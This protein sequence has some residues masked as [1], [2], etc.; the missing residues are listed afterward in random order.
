L[1]LK[2]FCLTV[3]AFGVLQQASASSLCTTGTLASYEALGAGGCQI[4][5]DT[6]G[7]FAII[8]GITGATAIDPALVEIKP[9][10]G[11]D[12]LVLKFD[13]TQTANA[14]SLLEAIFTYAISGPDPFITDMTTLSN[15]SETGDGDVSETQNY[16]VGGRFGPDGV[17][18]CTGST[19]GT[20]LTLDGIQNTD[21][22]S[23]TGATTLGITDDFVL[24][25]GTAGSASGGTF[26]D[27]FTATST[28]PEP[29]CI[30]LLPAIALVSAG[31]R[32]LRSLHRNS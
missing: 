9:S 18:G 19:S 25:G 26:V 32:K 21:Q 17:D 4:G 14:G 12:D 29:N 16:C 24:D 6:I 7:S 30:F 2:L 8:S 1:R 15:S 13:V 28:V 10:G 3:T 5:G 20:L 22:G 23:F 11:T 27:R 31:F